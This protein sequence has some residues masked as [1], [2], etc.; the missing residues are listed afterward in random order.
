MK[1]EEEEREEYPQLFA[2]HPC[3]TSVGSWCAV[4]YAAKV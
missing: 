2:P 4:K 3:V 1:E